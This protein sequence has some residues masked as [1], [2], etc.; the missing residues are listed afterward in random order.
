MQK[1]TIN[2]L[3]NYNQ[4]YLNNRWKAG[5]VLSSLSILLCFRPALI[6]LRDAFVSARTDFAGFEQHDA[7]E[8]L[9]FYFE[10]LQREAAEFIARRNVEMQL[11]LVDTTLF[12]IF[13]P[14]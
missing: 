8:F 1:I 7:Q 2:K 10:S 12:H 13:K 14:V 3:L 11:K 5:S 6:A 4:S 9:S